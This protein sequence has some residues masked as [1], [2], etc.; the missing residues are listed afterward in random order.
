MP[1]VKYISHALLSLSHSITPFAFTG[2]DPSGILADLSKLHLNRLPFLAG[3]SGPRNI[4]RMRS[5]ADHA[6]EMVG[7]A[8]HVGTCLLV[9]LA[10]CLV[11]NS[12]RIPT[13]EHVY[14][15][16]FLSPNWLLT[17]V[18]QSKANRI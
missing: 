17:L 16:K 1:T 14:W 15:G 5:L 11:R 2:W 8:T 4:K 3:P 7:E 10:T 13:T 12:C 18:S 6:H 9:E